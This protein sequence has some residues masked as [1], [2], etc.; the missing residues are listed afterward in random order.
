MKRHYLDINRALK[1]VDE[2]NESEPRRLVKGASSNR[3]I[4]HDVDRAANSEVDSGFLGGLKGGLG[5]KSSFIRGINNWIQDNIYGDLNSDDEDDDYSTDDEGMLDARYGSVKI[6]VERAGE[7]IRTAAYQANKMSMW[8]QLS[9]NIE[10]D[11]L[12][13][14]LYLGKDAKEKLI[15]KGDNYGIMM[16]G[17]KPRVVHYQIVQRQRPEVD[18]D[19]E[20][21]VSL[22]TKTDSVD[23]LKY[24]PVIRVTP[25]VDSSWPPL[26]Q[27]DVPEAPSEV[28]PARKDIEKK[29]KGMMK[30]M[31]PKNLN[32]KYPVFLKKK[33]DDADSNH[34]KSYHNFVVFSDIPYVIPPPPLPQ[35]APQ[36]GT[37]D[38]EK[39]QG[40]EGLE[41]FTE[42]LRSSLVRLGEKATKFQNDVH[43]YEFRIQAADREITKL[44]AS[45]SKKQK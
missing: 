45:G 41:M 21:E 17:N 6:N 37:S 12:S 16:R 42:D 39:R 11:R 1:A 40:A 14:S 28:P 10:P 34:H 43:A 29:G 35:S 3:L 4:S 5:K 15:R 2:A 25:E 9:G 7:V 20:E 22:G 13:V 38:Q 23:E 18:I 36:D 32:K 8:Q 19:R 44:S 27:S 30:K 33:K 31:I 26:P 24:D